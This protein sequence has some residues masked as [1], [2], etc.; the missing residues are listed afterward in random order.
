[1]SSIDSSG[2]YLSAGTS[3][4]S[5][6]TSLSTSAHSADSSRSVPGAAAK[7]SSGDARVYPDSPDWGAVESSP[8][9][10]MVFSLD[11]PGQVDRVPSLPL[12]SRFA[13]VYAHDLDATPGD[14]LVDADQVS[15]LFDEVADAF[16]NG[17]SEFLPVCDARNLRQ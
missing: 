5:S 7:E 8:M 4:G 13:S 14:S 10:G 16:C 11:G 3:Q 9:T 2:G 6:F 15:Q 17:F 12:T 1:M